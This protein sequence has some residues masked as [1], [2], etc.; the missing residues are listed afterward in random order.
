[1]ARWLLRESH[2]LNSPGVYWEQQQTDRESGRQKRVQYP[3]PIH[4]NPNDPS[5]WNYKSGQA[6]VSQGGKEFTDGAIIVCHE[7]KGEAKDIVFIG[8]PTPGMEPIDDEAKEISAKFATTWN[9]DVFALATDDTATYTNHVLNKAA[10]LFGEAQTKANEAN[11][12]VLALQKDMKDIMATM[13][14]VMTQNAE[15]LRGLVPA[16]RAI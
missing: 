4:L 8:D 12:E 10:A 1:M 11:S 14:A 2:Y 6:H 16:R 7:G 9:Y 3:V 13:A 15:L 5:D